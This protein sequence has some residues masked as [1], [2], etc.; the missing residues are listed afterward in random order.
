MSPEAEDVRGKA[1]LWTILNGVAI[2][3]CLNLGAIVGVIL[4][5][6]AIGRSRTDVASAR[7]LVRWSWIWFIIGFVV[8]FLFWTVY[9]IAAIAIGV[10]AG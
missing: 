4:A 5:A 1:V 6:M 9:L 3:F 2:A 7:R 8:G 10:L